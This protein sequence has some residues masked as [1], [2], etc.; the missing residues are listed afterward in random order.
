MDYIELI[1]HMPYKFKGEVVLYKVGDVHIDVVEFI[2]KDMSV[3][4]NKF[5][6]CDEDN[7]DEDIYMDVKV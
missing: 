6:T 7:S 2:F 5:R 1:K 3:T 4:L